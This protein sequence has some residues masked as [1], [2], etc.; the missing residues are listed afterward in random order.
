MRNNGWWGAWYEKKHVIIFLSYTWYK[1][2]FPEI[3]ELQCDRDYW[4]II[5]LSLPL[6]VQLSSHNLLL[7]NIFPFTV[8]GPLNEKKHVIIFLS[9]TWYKKAFPEI[10][11][12]QCDA[13]YGKVHDI[14]TSVWWFVIISSTTFEVTFGVIR[15]YRHVKNWK[16]D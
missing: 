2:T 5:S 11:E 9:Y 13:D 3:D 1:K 7:I 14:F 4:T 10:D 6:L 16:K 12:L 8:Q 15:R